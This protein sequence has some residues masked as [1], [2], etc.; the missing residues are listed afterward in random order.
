MLPGIIQHL[1][2]LEEIKKNMQKHEYTK[3]GLS[4]TK[5]VYQLKSFSSKSKN[6][7]FPTTSP[8]T[9]RSFIDINIVIALSCN[10]TNLKA[11]LSQPLFEDSLHNT[12]FPQLVAVNAYEEFN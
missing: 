8:V 9:I 4:N 7:T 12:I 3:K 1:K 10:F 11:F 2:E 5:S 6:F